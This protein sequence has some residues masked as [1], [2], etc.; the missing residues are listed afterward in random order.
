MDKV[1]YEVWYKG[2]VEEFK[3]HEEALAYAS[4]LLQVSAGV[5]VQENTRE[6]QFKGLPGVLL[7]SK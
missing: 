5:T 1:I 4:N 7:W 3:T 6:R 2:N